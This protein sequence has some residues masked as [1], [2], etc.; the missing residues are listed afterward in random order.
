MARKFVF[1]KDIENLLKQGK[2]EMQL[3][4]GSRFSP[5]AR[6]L[7]REKN[8][9]V[10]F[11]DRPLP[12]NEEID[13][14]E[15]QKQAPNDQPVSPEPALVAV[16]SDDRE[17]SGP[18]G[19]LAGRSAYFLI[20]DHKGRFI[21]IVK[22]PYS[23]ANEAIAPRVADLLAASQVSVFVAERFGQKIENALTEKNIQYF[24]FSGPIEEA[25]KVLFN[26]KGGDKGVPKHH[27]NS[28]I[29]D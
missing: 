18:T 2:S 6:D 15:N 11:S 21:D 10:T 16:A 27:N 29:T 24:E 1:I 8:I 23:A 19:Q 25:V 22:N 7:I 28:T 12:S 20:F 9:Q 4:E 17:P 3:P 26:E 13:R 5:A 14:P